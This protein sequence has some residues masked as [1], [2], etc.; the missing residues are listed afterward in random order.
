MLKFY[1]EFE[2]Y[3][4]S[5]DLRDYGTVEVL[6]TDSTVQ[7]TFEGKELNRKELNDICFN[8]DFS[9]LWNFDVT[10]WNGNEILEY[11]KSE[12]PFQVD[13]CKYGNLEEDPI[14]ELLD[15]YVHSENCFYG[16][17]DDLICDYQNYTNFKEL[18]INHFV[19]DNDPYE[20]NY[21]DLQ[22]LY[23]EIGKEEM[24][25]H[26]NELKEIENNGTSDEFSTMLDSGILDH[27]DFETVLDI[28]KNQAY[29]EVYDEINHTFCYNIY[30]LG[31]MVISGMEDV[32]FSE[33]E[34]NYT[35]EEIKAIANDYLA[36]Y[37]LWFFHRNLNII[38]IVEN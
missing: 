17:M 25:K 6:V 7:G 37:D 14:N 16:N 35:L 9:D 23:N 22:F 28:H 30:D 19:T 2:N 10:E 11:L 13:N 18:V 20:F 32:I 33:V 31:E 36:N 26:Y 4:G 8:S 15:D 24:R 21:L 38:C 3:N 27:V 29:Y 34:D 12:Y 5:Q 1:I